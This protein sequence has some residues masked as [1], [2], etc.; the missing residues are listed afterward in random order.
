MRAGPGQG[1]M[2]QALGVELV[3]LGAGVLDESEV[4]ELLELVEDSDGLEAAV[5]LDPADGPVEPP[6]SFL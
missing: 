6:L 4:L 1:R 5:L 3:V 2:T